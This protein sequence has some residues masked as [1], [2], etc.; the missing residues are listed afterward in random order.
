ME[1]T[2]LIFLLLHPI[3]VV[4]ILANLEPHL[5]F[6]E[7]A[8]YVVSNCTACPTSSELAF[9]DR[10]GCRKGGNA[11]RNQNQPKPEPAQPDVA[12]DLAFGLLR[13]VI[14]KGPANNNEKVKK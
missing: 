13:N 3:L 9:Y 2:R 12:R 6:P 7:G 8:P 5:C 10:Y 1:R 14:T 11:N 4:G